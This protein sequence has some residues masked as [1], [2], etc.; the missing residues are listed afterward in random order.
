MSL[1]LYNALCDLGLTIREA[2]RTLKEKP[3]SERGHE[4]VGI[5]QQQ[6][7]LTKL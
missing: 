1:V 7:L 2:G 5:T 6:P 4:S 3:N